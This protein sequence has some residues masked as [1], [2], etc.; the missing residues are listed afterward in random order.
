LEEIV[1]GWKDILALAY[2]GTYQKLDTNQWFITGGG[3]ESNERLS[4][5]CI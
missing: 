2:I 1:E 4:Q 5:C 3:L